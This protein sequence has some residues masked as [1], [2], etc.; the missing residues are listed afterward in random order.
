MAAGYNT[1]SMGTGRSEFNPKKV[2][3]GIEH[4]FE[5]AAEG[6]LKFMERIVKI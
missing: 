4:Y 2:R 1:I 5:E 6:T 3:P